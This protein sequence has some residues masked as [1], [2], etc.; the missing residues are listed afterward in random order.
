MLLEALQSSTRS[1]VAPLDPAV[2][3]YDPVTDTFGDG[4]Y[5]NSV[6]SIVDCLVG[7]E[8]GALRAANRLLRVVKVNRH[9]ETYVR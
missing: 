8:S 3:F 4:V 9:L 5:H 2:D 1:G 6:C 7:G